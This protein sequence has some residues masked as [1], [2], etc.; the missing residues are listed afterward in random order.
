MSNYKKESERNEEKKNINFLSQ[1]KNEWEH[2]KSSAP[3][4]DAN[5]FDH[6][7]VPLCAQIPWSEKHKI[8]ILEEKHAYKGPFVGTNVEDQVSLILFA[9]R[10]KMFTVCE[11]NVAS[12]QICQSIVKDDEY[13]IQ[14][15][16]LSLKDKTE[17]KVIERSKVSKWEIHHKKAFQLVDSASMNL[18]SLDDLQKELKSSAILWNNAPALCIDVFLLLALR[19]VAEPICSDSV[20]RNILYRKEDQ[21]VF[22]IDFE[23]MLDNFQSC[24]GT[25]GGWGEKTFDVYN[26]HDCLAYTALNVED[27][28]N[29]WERILCLGEDSL[30]KELL[31]SN[32]HA[33]K[34][35]DNWD[36]ILLKLLKQN[37]PFSPERYRLVCDCLGVTNQKKF[38]YISLEHNEEVKGVNAWDIGKIFGGMI[39]SEEMDQ[40]HVDSRLLL[41]GRFEIHLK[42]ADPMMDERKHVH[43]KELSHLKMNQIKKIVKSQN[44]WICIFK[45]NNVK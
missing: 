14:M 24:L 23:G 7:S 28:F 5:F 31:N 33:I 29:S 20:F 22:V 9:R 15:E 43:L 2:I 25:L 42:C 45:A 35:R 26:W 16:Q 39:S 27:A 18:I 44:R 37:I 3:K 11:I 19:F 17:W 32:S 12:A 1:H 41:E 38:Q 8:V 6:E 30:N 10:H 13:W 4:I 21:K 40:R 36:Q 34:L